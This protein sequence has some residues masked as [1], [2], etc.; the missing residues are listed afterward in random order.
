MPDPLTGEPAPPDDLESLTMAE[1][2]GIVVASH[3]TLVEQQRDQ[4]RMWAVTLE[5][6]LAALTA[7]AQEAA[8]LIARLGTTWAADTAVLDRLNETLGALESPP[9]TQDPEGDL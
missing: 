3:F 1:H 2:L 7:A 8:D 5:G 4:A 6:Q 9:D